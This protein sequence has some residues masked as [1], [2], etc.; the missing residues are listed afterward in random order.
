[1]D[2][3]FEAMDRRFV[4]QKEFMNAQFEQ[5]R[6]SVRRTDWLIGIG[7]TMVTVTVTLVGVLL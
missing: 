4:D 5:T 1:M 6:A 2:K 7:F 3:R